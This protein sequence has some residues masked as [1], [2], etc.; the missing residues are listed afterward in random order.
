MRIA[1]DAMGGDHA[2]GVNVDGAV[3]AARELG[4][5]S[6]LV[7]PEK[8]VGP[9]LREKG[10]GLP[11]E[12]VDAD[13]VVGM[14]ESPVEAI[15]K[16]RNSSLRVSARLVREGKAGA[17]VSA[18]NTGATLAA[19]K[20]VIGTVRGVDRPG[21]AMLLPNPGGFTVL[22]DVGANVDVKARHL[23]EFGVMGHFYSEI[24]LGREKPK[25]A[26]LSVGE[27]EGKGNDLTREA[28]ELLR[29]SGLNFVG[30]CEGRDLFRGGV[31]VVVCDGFTGNVVL[32]AS[33]ALGEMIRQLLREELGRDLRSKI[34]ALLAKPALSKMM[35]RVDYAEY[36]GAPML[37]LKG[38]CIVCH[39]RSN[40][41]AIRNALRVGDEFVRNGIPARVAAKVAEIE[42]DG[43]AP[44]GGTEASR[45]CS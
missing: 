45:G 11:I 14:D 10:Q 12:I 13:E 34:G 7:G 44:S 42:P 39:G 18:G 23:L 33:E 31:D 19:A 25:V 32:K 22:I 15:R 17:M 40:A 20:L 6:F 21:L 28:F 1:L 37:G 16:K 38:G 29:E 3:S 5:E 26:L 35:K 8:I 43:P 24:I 27:E 2:P 41:R 4:I 30:N 36:G 9:L